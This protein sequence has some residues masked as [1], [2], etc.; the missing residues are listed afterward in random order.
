ML[1]VIYT[2]NASII[3]YYYRWNNDICSICD[4]VETQLYLLYDCDY[5]KYI[6]DVVGTN[7]MKDVSINDVAIGEWC[8]NEKYQIITL[9]K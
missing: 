4:I 6:W 9:I 7:M 8:D 5:G 3:N 1:Y 2:I